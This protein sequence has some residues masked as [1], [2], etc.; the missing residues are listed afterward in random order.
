[1]RSAMRDLSISAVR[2][3][4]CSCRRCSA[5]SSSAPGRC[6][7]AAAVRA[8]G[9]RGYA[10]RVAQQV[11]EHPETAV[12]RM[13]WARRAVAGAYG[14]SPPESAYASSRGRYSATCLTPRVPR[15]MAGGPQARTML[16]AS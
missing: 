7:I 16:R 6:A 12:T 2:A 5:V 13:R 1:M 15:A 14:A 9:E 11:G 3:E 4:A 8:F 10:E